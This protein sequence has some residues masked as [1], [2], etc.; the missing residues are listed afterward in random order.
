MIDAGI[1]GLHQMIKLFQE[2]HRFQ[3][4]PAAVFVGQPLAGLARIIQVEHGSDGIHAQAVN[5]KSVA[6]EKGVGQEEIA[7]LVT[8]V[9]ENQRA[10]ILVRA[11][12]RV[13]VLVESG[14]V[15]ARQGPVVP[16]K[17]RRDPI[18]QHADAGLMELV[19]QKLEILRRPEA[20]GRARKTPSPDSPMKDKKRARP[21]A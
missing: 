15:E 6:P 20:A 5:M 9:I 12:A 21:K 3:V 1:F 4:L 7:D 16:R 11:F 19:D 13:F 17:M 10:P 2:F 8:A 14:A 18:Q